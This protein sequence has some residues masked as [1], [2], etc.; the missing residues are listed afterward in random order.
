MKRALDM[1]VAGTALM[2]TAPLLAVLAAAVKLDSRGPALFKQVRVGRFGRPIRI[3]KLRTM[4]ADAEKRGGAITAASDHRITRVGTFLRKSKLDEL[5]QL[6]NVLR[7]DM[8]LVGP[9]PE[10]ERYVKQYR[11][12]WLPLLGARPGLTDL[13]SLTF[14]D[15]EALLALA[16]DRERAYMDV[17]MPMKLALALKGLERQDLVGDLVVLARTALSVLGVRSSDE[18]RLLAEARQRIE[19]LNRARGEI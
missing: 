2:L 3:L 19:Q 9:R 1:A 4:V 8:S 7:G 16:A 5:P 15:E 14:R 10:V 6:W 11:P 12:E 17:I 13:A 18:A